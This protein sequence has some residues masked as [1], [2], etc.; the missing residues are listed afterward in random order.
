MGDP[1]FDTYYAS[2]I[3]FQ[4][5]GPIQEAK[6]QLAGSALLRKIGPSI[7]LSHSQGGLIPWVI[8][9]AVPHL[10][11]G[12]ISIEPTGPPFCE[13]IFSSTPARPYGL[14]NIPLTYSPA[15]TNLTVPLETEA[16]KND[17]EGLE[18]CILQKE[19]AR[20][21]ANFRGVKVL[22]VTSQASYHAPYDGCTV[23][24][25]KQAGVDTEW[26]RLEDVGILGNG[27]LCFMERNSDDIAGV[28]EER[29][30]E[31]VG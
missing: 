21:L 29:V 11:K 15:P 20:R 2:T 3:Q 13:A 14:T 4:S 1:I 12:I 25:L 7:L 18:T 24:F 26:L 10:V 22:V 5:S 6:M 9:D 19:P 31:M 30:K 23:R 17:E 16:V 8:T 28:L 27:H